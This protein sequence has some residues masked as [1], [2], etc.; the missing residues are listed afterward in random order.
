MLAEIWNTN[1]KALISI[2]TVIASV[3]TI[4]GGIVFIDDRYVQAA[5]FAIQVQEQQKLITDFRVQ[6]L[7]NDIF[8]LEFKEQSGNSSALDRA[9]KQRYKQQLDRLNK[10]NGR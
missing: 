4:Y 6:Q 5:D 9:L 10:M 1:K 3:T 8:Q 2:G 7:E